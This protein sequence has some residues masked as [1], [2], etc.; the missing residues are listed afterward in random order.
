MNKDLNQSFKKI[1]KLNIRFNKMINILTN[2][3]PYSY[4]NNQI[5]NL[6]S[7]QKI[8]L[9]N[10][11]NKLENEKEAKIIELKNKYQEKIEGNNQ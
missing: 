6:K 8:E 1:E 4:K 11:K 7:E 2:L 9:E 10:Q 5:K 3:F